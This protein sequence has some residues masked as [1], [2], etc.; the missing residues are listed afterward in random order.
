MADHDYTNQMNSVVG[1]IIAENEV[2]GFEEYWNLVK[3]LIAGLSVRAFYARTKDKYAN[4]AV[5]TDQSIIDIEADDDDADPGYITV[6]L[7][8]A[9]REVDFRTG[10]VRTLP[11]SSE[12]QLTMVLSMIG[13]TDTGSYWIA[14]TDEEREHLTRLGKALLKAINE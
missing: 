7:I 5:L 12:S 1:E 8:K 9:I 10:P 2:E 11:N 4:L 13:A 3:E 6:T 14:V